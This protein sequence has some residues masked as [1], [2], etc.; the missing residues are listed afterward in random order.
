MEPR[1]LQIP[2]HDVSVTMCSTQN[3]HPSASQVRVWPMSGGRSTG[4]ME[5][6]LSVNSQGQRYPWL[7]NDKQWW[8][9][10]EGRRKQLQRESMLRAPKGDL[11]Y[12]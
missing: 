12:E 2:K 8:D 9:L 3:S 6:P 11:K 7:G 10:F 4:W 1:R 5:G